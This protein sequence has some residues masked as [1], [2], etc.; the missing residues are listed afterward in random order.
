[1]SDRS[2]LFGIDLK[3]L[4]EAF[5]RPQ[6][7]Y[8]TLWLGRLVFWGGAVGVGVLA[9]LFAELSS[10]L[11]Q[12]FV[13]AAARHVW[14]PF[15]LTPLGGAFCVWLTRR[16]F[17]G[18]EGSGIPQVQAELRRPPEWRNWKPLLSVRIIFGKIL[19]GA[20]ALGCG[21][22]LGRE[23]PCVQV[24]ASLMNAIHGFLPTSLGIQ[25]QHLLVAG[26]AA[27]IAAAFNAPLAGILFAIEELTRGVE[28]RM[29]GLVITAIVLAGVTAQAL[30][31]NSGNFFGGGI[32]IIGGDSDQL[33]AV[34]L[35]AL[36]CGV[37]GGLF[38]RIM[39][40][41][42]S[43]WQ[44][45][46][47]RFRE[48]RPIRFAACCGFLVAALGYVSGGISFGSGLEQTRALLEAEEGNLPWH[49][50]PVKFVATLIA[51]LSGLPGGIFAPSLAIGAG[52]GHNLAPLL[53]QVDAPAMLLTLCMAGFLAATT[54]APITSF[55]IV[56]E[57]ADGYSI[58]LGLMMVS[59]I[60]S[61]I[62]R[63]FSPPLYSS[64]SAGMIE[65]QRPENKGK[66]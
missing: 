34:A 27:G 37:A 60:S 41:G 61:G 21:F 48:K 30:M 58:V 14:L 52:L 55:V 59:L 47:A 33:K 38:S 39:V 54:Q 42:A 40:L 20:S 44:G 7:D 5:R 13:T 36:V 10:A 4:R 15:V 8:L 22:S 19:V 64:L 63:F 23:G 24:G 66:G 53:Q 28:T 17:A 35:A 46:L 43:R 11:G 57:M 12:W 3:R 50:A 51:Y 65:R 56:M 16:F 32:L 45:W 29:S 49:F 62:S 31:G 6:A 25:R 1:M 9:V 2:S 18:A 26:G